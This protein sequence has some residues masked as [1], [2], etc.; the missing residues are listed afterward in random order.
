M[1]SEERYTFVEEGGLRVDGRV[2]VEGVYYV[3]R[4]EEFALQSKYAFA[5]AGSQQPF[6]KV[7]ERQWKVTSASAARA[8]DFLRAELNVQTDLANTFETLL[9]DPSQAVLSNGESRDTAAMENGEVTYQIPGRTKKLELALRMG[10]TRRTV[11]IQP[12]ARPNVELPKAT[13]KFPAYLQ[14]EDT[15][16]EVHGTV[17]SLSLIHI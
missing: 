13:V 5:D 12:V 16:R 11:T 7:L 3:P 6:W 2:Q 4:G 10:D 14:Y 8:D 1:S 9:P 15:D 17:F